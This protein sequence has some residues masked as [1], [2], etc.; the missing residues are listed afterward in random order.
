MS[1]P[2][3]R[4]TFLGKT[5]WTLVSFA[6][7]NAFLTACGQSG[8]SSNTSSNTPATGG[9]CDSDGTSTSIQVLHTPNHTLT[10]P[11]ADV[12]AGQAKTYILEDNGAGH[13]HQVTLTQADFQNL[14]SNKGIEESSTVSLG[15]SHTV[16]VSCA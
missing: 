4:R 3:D 9:N 10:I 8:Y 5:L 14:Q 7:V 15:H 16:T 13:T 2:I 1:H 11:L 12:L 6:G